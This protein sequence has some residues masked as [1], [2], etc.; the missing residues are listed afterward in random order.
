MIVINMVGCGMDIVLGGNWQVEVDVMV[1][2][3]EQDIVVVKQVWKDCNQVVK[4]VG[5]LYIIGMECYEF[6][7]IDNQ[8]CGCFGWQGDLGFICFFLLL[9]DNLMCIFVLDKVKGLM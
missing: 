6:C 5:G 7:R 1:F 9:E 3:I 4:D 2:F 8:L